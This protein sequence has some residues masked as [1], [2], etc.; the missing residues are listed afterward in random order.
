VFSGCGQRNAGSA[1]VVAR[2]GGRAITEADLDARLEDIPQLARPEYSGPVGRSRMLRQ[3]IEE[4]VLYRAALDDH[5]DRDAAV[6]RRL[7]QAKRQLLVQSYLD[8]EQAKMSRVDEKELRSF[9]D[10]HKDEYRIERM[11]RVRVLAA[12]NRKI[13]ERVRE[14][15][16]EG[17]P[18][19]GLCTKFSTDPYLKD[20]QGLLPTWVRKGK[21]VPWLG[22]HPAFH[23][24]VFSLK[25]GEIS[26]VF[27]T[28]KGFHVARVEDVREEQQRTFEE[29]RADI[30]ARLRRERTSKGLP[31]IVEDLK[32]RYAVRMVEP[33]GKSPEELWAEAQKA[34]EAATRVALY[35]ELV[36]RYPKDPHVVEALFMI[37]FTKSEELHDREGAEAAFKRVIDEFPE[38]E[39]AQS[40][41]WMLTSEG[42]ETPGFENAPRDSAGVGEATP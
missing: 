1:A 19:E 2:V 17:Q 13:A 29:A 25:K 23:D 32:R 40:A 28:P 9:Y 41:R 30:E 21:A 18:F 39:L 11:L 34:T 24:A 16:L 10:A 20:A 6:Q 35:Q 4:E 22:N 7:E 14:M 15:V 36:E 42:S 5:L 31:E 12:E 37:G 3:M 38:S 26:A 33:A 27:E 8:R